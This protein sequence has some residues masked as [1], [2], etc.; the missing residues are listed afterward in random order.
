MT[1]DE[2]D[3]THA[4]TQTEAK[5]KFR[6]LIQVL[7]KDLFGKNYVKIVGHSYFSY[8]LSYEPTTLGLLHM[9]CLVDR[10]VKYELII[11]N[12]YHHSG[13]VEIEKVTDMKGACEY[14]CKYVAKYGDLDIYKPKNIKEPSFSPLWYL[15]ATGQLRSTS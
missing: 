6:R 4:V 1:F 15:E 12:W 8:A 10:P 2:A 3:R 7:N 13:Y 11:S 14:V 5:F 9:H